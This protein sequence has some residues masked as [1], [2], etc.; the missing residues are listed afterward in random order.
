MRLVSRSSAHHG[1]QKFS[2]VG[3]AIWMR[4]RKTGVHLEAILMQESGQGQGGRAMTEMVSDVQQV[5]IGS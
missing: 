3:A 1:N 4:G 2:Q 5:S